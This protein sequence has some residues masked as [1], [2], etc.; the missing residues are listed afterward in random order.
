MHAAGVF[1][2]AHAG[3]P[4]LLDPEEEP[5]L[6]PEDDPELLPEEPPLDEPLDDPLEEPLDEPLD[7][8]LEEPLDEPLPPPLPDPDSLAASPVEASPS[9]ARTSVAPPQW[10]VTTK[11]T[12]RPGRPGQSQGA[13]IASSG[14]GR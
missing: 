8:P 9:P 10:A 6:P 13:R 2:S 4:P 1:G 11:S 3:P 12:I 7:E 14:D 5:E